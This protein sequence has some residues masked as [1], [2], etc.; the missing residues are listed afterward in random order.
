MVWPLNLDGMRF[1][2]VV[3]C[4]PIYRHAMVRNMSLAG[5]MAAAFAMA[6]PNISAALPGVA[7]ATAL[8][9]PLCSLGI[10]LAMKRWEVAGGAGLLFIT[11]AITIAFAAAFVFF[12]MGFAPAR[13]DGSRR[14]PRSLQV[15]ALL[16]LSLL[17]PLTVYSVQFVQQATEDRV[18]NQV[19]VEKVSEME[20]TEL[21]EWDSEHEGDILR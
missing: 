18:I 14:P 16:T 4:N 5:G 12:V 11:N 9:P 6:M 10:G 13:V 19:I 2:G 1:G 17:V 8:M 21:V 7:I 3:L 20:N 15:S